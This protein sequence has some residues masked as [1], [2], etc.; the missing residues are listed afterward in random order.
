MFT[1]P[2]SV[3]KRVGPKGVTEHKVPEPADYPSLDSGRESMSLI[4]SV[5][6]S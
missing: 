6:S 1:R 3:P 4:L 2:T 5:V